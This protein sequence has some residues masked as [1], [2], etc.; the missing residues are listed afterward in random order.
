ML[1]NSKICPM[2]S[3]CK[4]H[5]SNNNVSWNRFKYVSQEDLNFGGSPMVANNWQ[6]YAVTKELSTNIPSLA[7]HKLWYSVLVQAIEDLNLDPST[8]IN[9]SHRWFLSENYSIG[10]FIWICEA[11]GMSHK[12]LRAKLEPKINKVLK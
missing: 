2:L 12:K 7:A 10:S 5:N 11:L 8:S 4:K 6:D 9:S 1:C 3:E